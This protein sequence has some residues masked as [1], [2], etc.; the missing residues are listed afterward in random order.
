MKSTN[1]YKDIL[2]DNQIDAL[3]I[4]TPPSSHE[5][6]AIQA[7]QA[8]KHLIIE[9]PLSN[10]LASAIS[11]IKAAKNKQTVLRTFY[12]IRHDPVIQ[13]SKWLMDNDAIG[14]LMGI[15]VELHLYRSLDYWYEESGS[16]FEPNWRGRNKTSGGGFIISN[17][18]H[19]LDY[20][21]FITGLIFETVYADKDTLFRPVEVEDTASLILRGSKREMITISSSNAVLGNNSESIRLWGDCGQIIIRDGHVEFYSN[22]FLG[23]YAPMIWHKIVPGKKY[24]FRARFIDSF[25]HQ[26]TKKKMTEFD[27]PGLTSMAIVDAAYKSI[28]YGKKININNHLQEAIG[29]QCS[30]ED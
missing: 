30:N 25:H 26:I 16:K 5:S 22:H 10:T 27:E 13:L 28:E 2:K 3:L 7:I 8:G 1:N 6:I 21:S 20:L 15:S 19:V 17:V 18:I 9:K 11:I 24:D 29:R 14:Q 23:E 12:S 4:S